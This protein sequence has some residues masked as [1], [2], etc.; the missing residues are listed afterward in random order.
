MGDLRSKRHFAWTAQL[1]IK[2]SKLFKWMLQ[3]W[4]MWNQLECHVSQPLCAASWKQCKGRSSQTITVIHNREWAFKT[5][6]LGFREEVCTQKV[7]STELAFELHIRVCQANYA[8]SSPQ[9][10]LQSGLNGVLG[11]GWWMSQERHS[12]KGSVLGGHMLG[13][14]GA[15][16]KGGTAKVLTFQPC[17]G[18]SSPSPPPSSLQ[19]R[20][21]ATLKH[22]RRDMS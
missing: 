14:D 18:Q 7:P 22:S 21:M 12:F 20:G 3:S 15:R 9:Q 13:L 2:K 19:A 11:L 4:N 17:K 5:R 8:K 10:Q 1:L 6:R 16:V